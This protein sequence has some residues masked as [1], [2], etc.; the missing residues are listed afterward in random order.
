MDLKDLRQGIEDLLTR[1][2]LVRPD[3]D[4][5]EGHAKWTEWVGEYLYQFVVRSRQRGLSLE[6]C[7]K[8]AIKATER[9][10]R[11]AEANR[12]LS[13]ELPRD[14]TDDRGSEDETHPTEA[15]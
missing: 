8:H 2:T 9:A 13:Y 6:K 14:T 4:D 3:P 7:H 12:I 15:G 10:I 11:D 5:H 1:A